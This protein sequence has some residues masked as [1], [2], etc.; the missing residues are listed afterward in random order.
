MRQCLKAPDSLALVYSYDRY[1][2]R[3]NMTET[4]RKYLRCETAQSFK[5]IGRRLIPAARLRLRDDLTAPVTRWYDAAGLGE[6]LKNSGFCALRQCPSFSEW[7]GQAN[8]EEFAPFHVLCDGSSGRAASLSESLSD[9]RADWDILAEILE[10]LVCVMG[11]DVLITAAN[12]F[13]AAK[14]R[15]TEMRYAL[16]EVLQLVLYLMRETELDPRAL[17]GLAQRLLQAADRNLS[18]AALEHTDSGGLLGLVQT[19]RMRI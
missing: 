9:A 10:Q 12:T 2:L 5:P 19:E 16:F 3:S 18:G 7:L 15:S 11:P 4:F 13:Y 6:L 17:S 1:T 8:D 14:E